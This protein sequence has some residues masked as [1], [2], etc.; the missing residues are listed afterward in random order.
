MERCDGGL[1]LEEGA[2]Q[3]IFAA[4]GLEL[5]REP[6][7]ISETVE[8]CACHYFKITHNYDINLC[9]F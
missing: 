8:V 1:Q 2:F 9:E 7:T 5:L 6:S 4:V 3:L